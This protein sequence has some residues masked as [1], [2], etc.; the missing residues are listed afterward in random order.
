MV[1]ENESLFDMSEWGKSKEKPISKVD[2]ALNRV[3]DIEERLLKNL[4]N[5]VYRGDRLTSAD[6]KVLEDL[7]A[8]LSVR[9]E[10][11]RPEGFVSTAREV[12]E[13]FKRTVRTIRNWIGRGMPQE[14]DGYDLLKME[15]WALAEGI[16]KAP[17]TPGVQRDSEALEDQQGA[18]DRSHYEVEIKRLDSELKALKLAKETGE[19]ISRA[20]VERG[21]FD[22]AFEFKRELLGMARRLSLKGA[23]K[24]APALYELIRHDAMQ[25][26]RKYSRGHIDVESLS[27]APPAKKENNKC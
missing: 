10:A 19:L 27:D 8:G 9:Q 26:L 12:A 16:I 2:Q 6:Y 4:E 11:A 24:E 13:H 1:G 21:W 23:L 17:I 25:V 5:R 18:L 3:S 15:K 7:R 20:Q 14:V 22:R